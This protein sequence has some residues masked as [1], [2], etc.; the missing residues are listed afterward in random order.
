ME[1]PKDLKKRLKLLE[2]SA[3]KRNISVNLNHYF[4]GC[5]MHMDCIFCGKSLKNEK[6]Y[7]LDRHD[8]TKGYTFDNVSPCCKHCNQAKGQRTPEEYFQWIK[9]S[10][11]YQEKIRGVVKGMR[12]EENPYRRKKN[13][14]RKD[15]ILK[16]S[17]HYRN[18]K[19]L[20]VEGKR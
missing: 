19:T 7:S 10:Y 2:R 15:N 16:N 20:I 1:L 12:Q 17:K 6:G 13:K 18:A 9:D 5:L 4:Y 11:R 8:N 14:K 3:K